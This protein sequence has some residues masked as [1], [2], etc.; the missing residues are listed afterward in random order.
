MCSYIFIHL[1]DHDYSIGYVARTFAV[2]DISNIP[3]TVFLADDV[4]QLSEVVV[5]PQRI[6]HKTAGRKGAGGFVYIEVEGYKAAG[7]GLATT[8]NVS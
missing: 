5:K 1:R 2:R 6:K 8:L 3:D 7:Q 4:V